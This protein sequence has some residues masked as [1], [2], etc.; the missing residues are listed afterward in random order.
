M[1]A[2]MTFMDGERTSAEDGDMLD[3]AIAGIRRY[4]SETDASVEDLHVRYH[5]GNHYDV[6]DEMIPYLGN[7]SMRDMRRAIDMLFCGKTYW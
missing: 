1:S 5:W 6:Y 2:Q 3:R 4:M 7:C